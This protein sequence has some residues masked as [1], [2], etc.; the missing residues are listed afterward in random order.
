MIRSVR[1]M[2]ALQRSMSDATTE[3]ERSDL[4]RRI[5]SRDQL[6]DQLVYELYGVTEEERTQIEIMMKSL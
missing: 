4:E 3:N 1:Q 6:I 5:T 2:N